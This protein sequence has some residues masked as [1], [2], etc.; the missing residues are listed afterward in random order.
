[1]LGVLLKGGGW[2]KG[3]EEK[4]VG[5]GRERGRGGFQKANLSAFWLVP[6]MIKRGRFFET[7]YRGLW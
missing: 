2:G 5:G 6:S 4:G 7:G 1:M 3:V